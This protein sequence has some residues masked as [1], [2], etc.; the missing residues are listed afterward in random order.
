MAITKGGFKEASAEFAKAIVRSRTHSIVGGGD[1]L[2]LVSKMD[3]N[4]PLFPLEEEP[5][6]IFSRAEHC[7]GLKHLKGVLID[8]IVL[9]IYEDF[10]IFSAISANSSFG[11]DFPVQCL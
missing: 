3:L 5:C 7:R 11:K 2:A 1:T 10:L 6:L 4:F 9:I 8:V